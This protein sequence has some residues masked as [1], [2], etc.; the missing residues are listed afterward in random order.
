MRHTMLFDY[1]ISQYF[2]FNYSICISPVLRVF[3]MPLLIIMWMLLKLFLREELISKPRIMWVKEHNILYLYLCVNV[4]EGVHFFVTFI[5]NYH[6]IIGAIVIFT[7]IQLI[8]SGTF[9]NWRK[10]LFWSNFETITMQLHW[11]VLFSKVLI[12]WLIFITHYYCIIHTNIPTYIH[13]VIM[14]WLWT[15]DYSV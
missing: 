2:Q 10:Y 5:F 15:L 8:N 4:Y 7:I 6:T 12:V 3:C 1:S 11:C 14:I 13:T 9:D